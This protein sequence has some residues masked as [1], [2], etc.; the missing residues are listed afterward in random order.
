MFAFRIIYTAEG[1][2]SYSGKCGLH[3]EFTLTEGGGENR[4]ENWVA[5]R[6][7]NKHNLLK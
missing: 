6:Q 1:L 7:P 5:G 4:L 3:P 2:F